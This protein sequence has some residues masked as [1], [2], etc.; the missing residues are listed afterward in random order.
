MARRRALL[1]YKSWSSWETK[2]V[3][4]TGLNISKVGTEDDFYR[5]TIELQEMPILYIGRVSPGI[6]RTALRNTTAIAIS[7]AVKK[8]FDATIGKMER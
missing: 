4:I 1:R 3:V 7:N 8:T 5:A 6:G 2:T